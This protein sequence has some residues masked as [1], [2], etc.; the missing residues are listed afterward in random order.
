MYGLS[1]NVLEQENNEQ[2][3]KL[4]V[5][6]LAPSPHQ[7]AVAWWHQAIKHG[8]SSL[9]GYEVRDLFPWEIFNKI[10][11]SCLLNVEKIWNS[12]QINWSSTLNSYLRYVF[13]ATISTEKS[14]SE[15]D[16]DLAQYDM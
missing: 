13:Y 4:H 16:A 12:A 3:F 6:S 7:V 8:D 5:S 15:I 10:V 2:F 9:V 11:I 1:G 14:T